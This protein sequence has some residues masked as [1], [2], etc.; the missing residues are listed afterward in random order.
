MKILK[1]SVDGKTDQVVPQWIE[2][3]S[4]VQSGGYECGYYFMHW[5]WNIVSSDVAKFLLVWF[6]Y[7]NFFCGI[8]GFECVYQ[9]LELFFCYCFFE[10]KQRNVKVGDVHGDLKQARSALEMVVDLSFD[11]QELWT[12]GETVNG[13]HKTMN[14]EGDFRYVDS[15]RFD[16]C[17]D[18]LEYINGSAGDWEETFNSWVD[19]SERCKE[20]QT[21]SKSYWGPWNLLK[22]I[23]KKESLL[24]QRQNKI[25]FESWYSLVQTE[26]AMS[27]DP[28][29][30]NLFL[31]VRIPLGPG[32]LLACELARH[33]VVLKVND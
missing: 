31:Y 11:G 16:E 6:S 10:I 29:D 27:L 25:H 13:N 5:M 9:S 24:D 3:K 8:F 33:V 14:V 21:M 32:G 19:V 26:E 28:Y 4:Y 2:V 18:F 20:D 7:S 12:G 30:C 15:A 23:D 22:D 1:T 17:N